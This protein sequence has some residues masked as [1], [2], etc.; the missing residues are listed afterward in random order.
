VVTQPDQKKGRGLHLRATAV[1]CLAQE[2][3]RQI[4]QPSQINTPEAVDFLK[5]LQPDLFVVAAYGQ[6]LSQKILDIPK[7]FCIN[8][9]ASLLPKYRGAAPINWAIINGERRTGVSIMQMTEKM[10]AG[11]VILQKGIDISEGQT[12]LNLEQKLADLGAELLLESFKLIEEKD[13]RLIVQNHAEATFAPKLKKEDGLIHW[14]RHAEDISNLIRGCF[15]WPG[16][17]TYFRGKILKIHKAG[18]RLFSSGNCTVPA[19]QVINV[20]KNG[21]VVAAGKGSLIIEELQI[22]SKK[23][24]S[25]EEFIA[26]HRIYPGDKLG[27][28][29]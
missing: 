28:R 23:R 7:V 14:D 2:A 15:G 3:K 22:E 9:H 13:Y 16:A 17:F 11:P 25:A 29:I 1:K 18:V 20:D 26:G 5:G 10:D 6:I 4:Y 8:I 21:I 12:V 27:T 19:G 24:M